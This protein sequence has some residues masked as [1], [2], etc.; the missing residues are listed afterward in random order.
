[1]QARQVHQPPREVVYALFGRA[2]SA[3]FDR[4]PAPA[5]LTNA[6]ES[7]AGSVPKSVELAAGPAA[8]LARC[9][10]RLANLPNYALDR[11]G[12]YEAS[13]WRQAGQILF[14]LHVLDRRKPWDRRRGFGPGG[15]Q[16]LPVYGPED[17]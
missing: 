13:L 12:R 6:T 5:N 9:F 14:A 1:M 2:E 16:D 10:L 3:S 7:F 17:C 11:L 8:E 15:R 4:D